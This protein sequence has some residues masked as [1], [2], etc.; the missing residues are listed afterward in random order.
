MDRHLPNASCVAWVSNHLEMLT[1]LSSFG[2]SIWCLDGDMHRYENSGCRCTDTF[3]RSKSLNYVHL[4]TIKLWRTYKMP[5][6]SSY[7]T[8]TM[9]PGAIFWQIS[10]LIRCFCEGQFRHERAIY[11]YV[12]GFLC[13]G[14]HHYSL[15][16]EM[17]CFRTYSIPCVQ[18]NSAIPWKM[19]TNLSS[20]GR[21]IL[22]LVLVAYFVQ[23]FATFWTCR[24]L[25]K[26][27]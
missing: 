15:W 2:R 8:K 1:N 23:N 6:G 18:R 22:G 20:S 17:R 19:L 5:L 13:P 24:H 26:M 4:T 3:L 9:V 14:I 7:R 16:M 27:E 25:S 21:S 11:S 12:Y 10:W